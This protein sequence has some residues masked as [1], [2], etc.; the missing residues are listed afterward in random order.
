M[1]IVTRSEPQV[2]RV[3]VSAVFPRPTAQGGGGD[4]VFVVDA[5]RA[6]LRAVQIGGRNASQA[7]LLGGLP[8]GAAVIVYPGA[9]VADGVRVKVRRV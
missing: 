8:A 2:L 4:A 1:R 3:P 5:G 9:A 6:S 7:W